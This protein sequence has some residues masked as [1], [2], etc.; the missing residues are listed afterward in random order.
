MPSEVRN[1]KGNRVVAI[2]PVGQWVQAALDLPILKQ[3]VLLWA[4]SWL[5]R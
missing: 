5:S 3:T 2:V 1:I 4:P